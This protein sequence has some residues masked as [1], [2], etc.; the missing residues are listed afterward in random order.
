[1]A[2]IQNVCPLLVKA[3]SIISWLGRKCLSPKLPVTLSGF[4]GLL[5]P[6]G[7]LW[8]EREALG[9]AC[10]LDT[11]VQCSTPG[12][13]PTC[14]CLTVPTSQ[15]NTGPANH[16]LLQSVAWVVS[17]MPISITSLIWSEHKGIFALPYTPSL[18]GEQASPHLEQRGSS[19]ESTSLSL[20]P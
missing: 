15:A 19:F 12:A 7:M 1:M 20:Q 11:T 13:A 14:P 3:H 18:P 10:P 9:F 5:P 4:K 6:Q 2:L 8:L 17:L 16:I